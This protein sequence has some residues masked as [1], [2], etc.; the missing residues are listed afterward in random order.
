MS[1]EKVLPTEQVYD[2]WQAINMLSE[3]SS[4]EFEAADNDIF[5]STDKDTTLLAGDNNSGVWVKITNS[6]HQNLGPLGS[7]LTAKWKLR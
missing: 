7:W 6:K 2:T 3:N 4:L 5:L 1:E